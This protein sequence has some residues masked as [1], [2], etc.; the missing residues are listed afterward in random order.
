[1]SDYR[2]KWLILAS[3]PSAFGAVATTEIINAA[4]YYND[5]LERNANIV[6]LT[7]DNIYA[8]LAWVYDIYQKT[9]IT[10]PF[11]IISDSD[12]AISELYGMLNPDRAFV[13]SVR[14]VFLIDPSGRIRAIITLPL[15]TGR[16]S[17]ELIRIF[18]SIQVEENYN[19]NTPA[20]WQPGDPV[21]LPNPT[22]YEELIDRMNNQEA[23]G[24]NCPSWYVCYTYLN[25]ESGNN[26]TPPP[27]VNDNTSS[28]NI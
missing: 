8:N 1:M 7:T 20:E 9:G 14:D 5:L 24:Y 15:S 18:E 26:A 25:Q 4:Q 3:S 23:L 22:S 12:L 21:L 17:A 11:P 27:E 10:I 28:Q 13:E 19:F 16:N 6:A 2:G